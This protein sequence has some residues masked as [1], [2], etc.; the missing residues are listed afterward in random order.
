MSGNKLTGVGELRTRGGSIDV[1]G[2]HLQLRRGTVTFQ[3]NIANPVLSIEALRTGLAVQ[4]GVRV[5]GTARK[6]KIDL[7]SYPDV[8]E[9][10]KL[11][12]L[13]LG[14][15][16]DEGGGDVALLFSVG[17][18][19]VGGG[20]PF[21][22]KLGLDE[23]S[24]RTGEL[25]STGSILPPESVVSS[26]NTNPSEAEQQFAQVGKHLADGV[27]LSLEQALASTGTVGRLSYRLS[28]RLR[29]ELSAGTVSGVALI[30]HVFFDN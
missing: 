19:I 20:E 5:S 4:A 15:A 1:Y 9:T 8:S 11:S 2:Q 3:G 25:G 30:Y 23:L 13:L 24:I 7:V 29:A 28:R 21:Y 27:T 6:P 16:P 18:S 10:E 22:R 14:R 26:A 17:A 12:W